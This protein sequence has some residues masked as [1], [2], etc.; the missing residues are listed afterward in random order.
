MKKNIRKIVSYM[1]GT[2]LAAL[3]LVGCGFGLD[4]GGQDTQNSENP[5]AGMECQGLFLVMENDTIGEILRLYSYETGLEYH[6]KY[7]FSTSF[8]DKYGKHEPVVRFTPG[9]VVTLS[10]R[11]QF[12][13]LT[14][15]RISDSTWEQTKVRRF[16]INEEKGVFSIAGTNY[17]IQDK[18]VIFSNG[19]EMAFSDLTEKDVLTVVGLD[20]KILSINVTTGHGTLSLKNTD[21]FEGSLLKLNND[22]YAEVTEDMMMELQEGTYTL[23]VANDGWGSS[24]E[25]TIERGQVTEVDLDGMKGPGKKKGQISFVTNVEGAKVYVDNQL[26]DHSQ[27][28]ELTY[29][30]HRV[31]I[32]ATGYDIWKRYLVVNSATANIIIEMTGSSTT[33]DSE[34]ETETQKESESESDTEAQS[35]SESVSESEKGTERE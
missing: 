14:E 25:I 7:N 12:G 22:M 34:S 9:K 32:V 1:T 26:V 31:Q 17:S 11:D 21:L 24:R 29:G 8:Y 10:P 30:T 18:V 28:V 27:P 33:E 15:V 16:T 4:G 3:L 19:E 23:T 20:K 13:Y 5:D 6:Y 35:T 2:L